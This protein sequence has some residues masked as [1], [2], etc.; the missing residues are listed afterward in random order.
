MYSS[1]LL[2]LWGFVLFLMVFY[3]HPRRLHVIPTCFLL[4]F[5]CIL[6]Y[7]FE[8][9]CWFGDKIQDFP[10]VLLH[11]WSFGCFL[12]TIV[13]LIIYFDLMPFIFDIT[14]IE[15][16][17]DWLWWSLVHKIKFVC[18]KYID[19]AGFFHLAVFH[20]LRWWNL[21]CRNRFDC[22]NFFEFGVFFILLVS[23]T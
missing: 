23:M 3:K 12:S 18:C 13:R 4:W 1:W 17:H 15:V 20:D 22:C 8:I 14:S 10:L 9:C 21:G 7:V 11:I 16:F 2:R 6:C 5:L 19:F